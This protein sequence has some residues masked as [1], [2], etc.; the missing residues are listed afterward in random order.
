M[1]DIRSQLR[2]PRRQVRTLLAHRFGLMPQRAQLRVEVLHPHPQLARL[3]GQPSPIRHR[4]RPRLRQNHVLRGQLR[5]LLLAPHLLR[6]G[7][8]HLLL[9][10]RD[11]LPLPI[12]H[13]LRLLKRRRC[14]PPPLFQ[15]R[16]RGRSR[17]PPP[18]A[19]CS[20]SARKPVQL[21]SC[22][23]A[24][25]VSMLARSVSNPA[26][27]CCLRE[28]KSCFCPRASRLRSLASAHSCSRRSIRAVSDSICRSAAPEFADSRSASLR[29]ANFASS[30]AVSSRTSRSSPAVFNSACPSS[31]SAA[32]SFCCTSLNSRFNASGPCAAARPP[33]TVAL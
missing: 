6:A 23:S 14:I 26:A 19:N 13:A 30:V 9:D 4:T 5:R 7:R 15:P 2:C 33:V 24:S 16:Q 28:I 1:L 31:A 3:R 21:P 11:P 25:F 20:R 32:S 27:S 8:L 10:L 12:G 17:P 18:P 22:N 29:S